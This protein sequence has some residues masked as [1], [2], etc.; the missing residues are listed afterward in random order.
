MTFESKC[1]AFYCQKENL[2]FLNYFL[3]CYVVDSFK[4]VWKTAEHRM[5]NSVT[6]APNYYFSIGNKLFKKLYAL[7]LVAL[8]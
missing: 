6:A 8:F 2:V 7:V 1:Q 4:L 5:I 3:L